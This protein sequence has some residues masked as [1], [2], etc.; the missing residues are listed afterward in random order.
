MHCPAQA[1]RVSI[2]CENVDL[3]KL[4][5]A[6]DTAEIK[7]LMAKHTVIEPVEVYIEVD[8]GS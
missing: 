4:K 5:A 1:N 6:M 8:G 7:A 3:A 2:V